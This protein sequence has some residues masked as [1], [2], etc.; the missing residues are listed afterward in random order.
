[1][2]TK[3]E[4]KR[5]KPIIGS[6][7]TAAVLKILSAKRIRNKNGLPHNAT[8]VRMVFQGFRNNKE[9]ENA[10]WKLAVYKKK[11]IK[12]LNITKQRI[13]NNK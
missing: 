12:N 7:Y 3:N 1:M 4:Q 9:I 5:L 11:E 2:I 10:I 13:L 8:Y 6:H